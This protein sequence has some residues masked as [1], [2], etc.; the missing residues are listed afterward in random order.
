MT[1]ANAPK[2]KRKGGF[3]GK[4]LSWQAGQGGTGTERREFA[5]SSLNEAGRASRN[6]KVAHWT[7]QDCGTHCTECSRAA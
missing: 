5:K 6:A 7:E 4:F 2:H 3:E 1:P